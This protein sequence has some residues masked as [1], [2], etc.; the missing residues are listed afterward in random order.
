MTK[1]SV[2][3]HKPETFLLGSHASKFRILKNS[4]KQFVTKTGTSKRIFILRFRDLY[5][6]N[7]SELTT[8]RKDG[9]SPYHANAALEI[10]LVAKRKINVLVRFL[11]GVLKKVSTA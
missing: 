2:F 1:A 11:S 6:N 8:A 10:M 4:V 7:N 5:P 9:K 3:C